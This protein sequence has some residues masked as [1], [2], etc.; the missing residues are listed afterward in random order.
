MGCFEPAFWTSRAWTAF[1]H[2]GARIG[3][4]PTFFSTR[5]FPISSYI[6]TSRLLSSLVF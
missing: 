2:W 1:P 4:L 3:R 6:A 5:S